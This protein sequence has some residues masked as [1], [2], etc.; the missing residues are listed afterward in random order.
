MD[1]GDE[2]ATVV[3]RDEHGEVLSLAFDHESLVASGIRRLREKMWHSPIL[4][5][6]MPTKF[7]L[8]ALQATYEQ[9]LGRE[10]SP[11]NRASFRRQ[12]IQTSGLVETTGE[13]QTDVDHRPASLFRRARSLESV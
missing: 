11:L 9:V 3:L 4:F 10:N 2:N 6:V 1:L 12:M 7:T 5:E 13:M 8:R